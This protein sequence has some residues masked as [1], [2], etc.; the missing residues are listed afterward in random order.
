MIEEFE[1]YLEKK[2]IVSLLRQVNLQPRIIMQKYVFL[3]YVK[4][5]E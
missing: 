5:K 3:E 4:E 2:G 1:K